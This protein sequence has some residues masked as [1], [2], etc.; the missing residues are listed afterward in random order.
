MGRFATACQAF[1]RILGSDR[2]ARRWREGTIP[3][4]VPASPRAAKP[5]RTEDDI[6]TEQIPAPPPPAGA[7]AVY[8]LVVLQ[9][10]GRLVDFLQEDIA[11]YSDAQVGAAVRQ[12]HA[13]CR[14]ALADHF[15]LQPLHE[16]SED[17]Q[18]T[19]PVGF[20]PRQIRIS[21]KA[22]GEPPFVG[23]LRHRGWR[24]GKVDFPQRHGK[25]DPTVIQPA[26]VDV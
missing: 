7:D 19:V 22:T 13:R 26:E 4:A 21:G 3:E 23:T 14:K 20:D 11:G 17:Q 16:G 9:R 1:W 5:S 8:T 18:V 15:D 24:A 6:A 10:E 12:V 2:E 25:L